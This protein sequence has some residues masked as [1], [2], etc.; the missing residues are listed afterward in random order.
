MGIIVV[1]IILFI[2]SIPISIVLILIAGRISRKVP[3]M[4][5][6]RMIVAGLSPYITGIFF[7]FALISYSLCCGFRGM[8]FLGEDYQVPLTNGYYFYVF[9]TLEHASIAKSTVGKVLGAPEISDITELNE[10]GNYVY[11]HINDGNGFLLNT[12]SKVLL[13]ELSKDSLIEI[14]NNV[15]ISTPKFKSNE[16][17]YNKR[18]FDL[19]DIVVRFVL[20]I[21]YLVIMYLIWFEFWKASPEPKIYAQQN[22]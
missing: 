6:Q 22:V 12:K 21:P 8:D 9:G 10:T 14:L 4:R 16:S 17:F 11:G 15:G 20:F 7:I 1:P 18:R 3:H 5:K 2:L 13:K 19:I